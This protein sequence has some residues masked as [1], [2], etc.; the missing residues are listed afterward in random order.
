MSDPLLNTTQLNKSELLRIAS[1]AHGLHAAMVKAKGVFLG[2][3]MKA[4]VKSEK[5]ELY[6]EDAAR[7]QRMLD[8]D[9]T[10]LREIEM[11]TRQVL[12][13]EDLLA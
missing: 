13:A 9:Q 6:L 7:I 10:L 4:P 3:A 11:A 12:S 2:L 5:R 1:Q 8:A